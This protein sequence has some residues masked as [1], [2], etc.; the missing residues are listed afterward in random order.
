MHALNL[1]AKPVSLADRLADLA[2]DALIDEADLSPKPALV[3]RRGNGAHTDLHLG[4]MHASAL[5][6]W[7]AFK[8]MAEDRA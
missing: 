2:V 4:L 6:L 5:A 1:K 7:P 8:E 3:D